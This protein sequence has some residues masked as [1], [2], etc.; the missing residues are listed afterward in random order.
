M[1]QIEE[2]AVDSGGLI[3][4]NLKE[5]KFFKK[6][7]NFFLVYRGMVNQT[8]GR[9]MGLTKSCIKVEQIHDG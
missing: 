6:Q 3:D 8:S 5:K 9:R 4:G 2:A 7:G 1:Q